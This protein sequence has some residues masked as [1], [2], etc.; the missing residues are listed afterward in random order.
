[1]GIGTN[2]AILWFVMLLIGPLLMWVLYLGLG[3]DLAT[4]DPSI[5]PNLSQALPKKLVS[6][7]SAQAGLAKR[8]DEIRELR[9]LLMAKA[10]DFMAEHSWVDGWLKST[11]AYLC[12]LGAALS[13]VEP[14]FTQWAGF[15]ATP[16]RLFPRPSPWEARPDSDPVDNC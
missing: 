16:A 15:R 6:A 5:L 2:Q 13:V 7:L 12:G 4:H 11:D 8:I 3:S 14:G 10:P 1:M 9:E